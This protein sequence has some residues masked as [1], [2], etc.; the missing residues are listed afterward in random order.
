MGSLSS[1]GAR[2][3]FTLVELLVVMA[4]IALL[5]G[6][7]LPTLPRVMDAARKTRCAAQL[8]SVGQAL[9][10]YKGDHRELY[11]TARYMPPPW[12]SGDT[13]P[14]MDVVLASYFDQGSP[15][16]ECPGDKLVHAAEYTDDDGVERTCDVSYTYLV[17]YSGRRFDETFFAQRMNFNESEAPVMHDFDGGTFEKQ[18]GSSLTVDFFHSDRNFVYVD[19]H[20]DKYE[21]F[22]REQDLD[23][24]G[25]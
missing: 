18:N 17:A 9:E 24:A 5:I 3:G 15:A 6:L 16:W 10:L 12:L 22:T 21:D 14:P 8:R 23:A 19:G 7:L 20:V 25:N 2:P 1:G 4:I 11:P 13:D